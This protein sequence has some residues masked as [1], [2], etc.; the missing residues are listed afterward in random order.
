MK[1]SLVNAVQAISK[2]RQNSIDSIVSFANSLT[3]KLIQN[4]E[5]SLNFVSNDSLASIFFFVA[6]AIQKVRDIKTQK[7]V[8]KILVR[9]SFNPDWYKKLPPSR[10]PKGPDFFDCND[11]GNKLAKVPGSVIRRIIRVMA[12]KKFIIECS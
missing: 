9:M 8:D 5:H 10:L 7:M 1:K 11:L 6:P 4:K 2:R 3:A 12:E